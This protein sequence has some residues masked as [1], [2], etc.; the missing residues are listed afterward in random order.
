MKSSNDQSMLSHCFELHFSI[1][2]NSYVI[3][4]LIQGREAEFE[5]QRAIELILFQQDASSDMTI[6][7]YRYLFRPLPV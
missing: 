6:V 5:H 1:F 3:R 7:Y 4:Q 2:L